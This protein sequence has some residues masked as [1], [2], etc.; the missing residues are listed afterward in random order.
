ML[1]VRR[2]RVLRE[3]ARQGT[4]AAAARELDFTPSAVSQQI[5]TLEREAGIALVDRGPSSV[6][7]TEA[8][9]T[10]VVHADAVLGRLDDAEADLRAIGSLRAGGLRMAAFASVTDLAGR[11]LRAFRRGHPDLE[12]TMT[13]AETPESV[14][15]LRRGDFDVAVI[16]IYD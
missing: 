9:R 15:G 11:A 1:D 4:I 7:L 14:E 3:V 13:E 6:V 8:G 16:Y 10:L 5:S 2:M 12:L